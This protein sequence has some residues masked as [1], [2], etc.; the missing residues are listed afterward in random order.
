MV[1]SSFFIELQGEALVHTFLETNLPRPPRIPNGPIKGLLEKKRRFAVAMQH[2]EGHPYDGN[3]TLSL[4]RGAF[5]DP[6][7][8]RTNCCISGSIM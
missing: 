5:R 6:P 1:A 2:V 7:E 3:V 8:T 4:S